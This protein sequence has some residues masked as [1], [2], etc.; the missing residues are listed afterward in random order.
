MLFIAHRGNINGPNVQLENSQDYIVEALNLGYDCEIDVWLVDGVWYL[1]HD[2]PQYKTSLQF[3]EE[4]SERLWIHCKN[5]WS[6]EALVSRD[7][8]NCFVHDKDVYTITSKRI[9]WGN[10]NTIIIAGMICVMPE[11]YTQT[12]QTNELRVCAGICSDYIHQYKNMC[13]G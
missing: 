7:K 11:K 2:H 10:I 1:G 9:V 12:P 3:L 5:E 4:N 6:L 8:F 13:G